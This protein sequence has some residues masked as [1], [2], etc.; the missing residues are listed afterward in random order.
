MPALD[1][2]ILRRPLDDEV[3]SGRT[4]L[5]DGGA[6]LDPA[7]GIPMT[8]PA[9]AAVITPVVMAATAFVHDEPSATNDHPFA[10][11]VTRHTEDPLA[12]MLDS[13]QIGEDNPILLARC[14]D[15]ARRIVSAGGQISKAELARQVNCA[16]QTIARLMSRPVFRKVYN[17]VSDEVM[18]TIDDRII[19]ERLDLTARQDAQQ[20]RAMTLLA[21]CFEIVDRHAA[22]VIDGTAIARPGVLKLAIEAAAEVRQIGTARGGGGVGNGATVNINITRN[23]ATVIQGAIRE[24]GIDLSDVLG[25]MTIQP[26]ERI[27]KAS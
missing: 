2:A 18:G 12:D 10:D 25:E 16:P 24:S 1:L 9:A 14:D 17:E 13:P 6:L 15:V 3:W 4:P 26:I 27:E 22:Q 8:A 11:R 5:T 7:T 19:D 23:Q 20:R 21:R